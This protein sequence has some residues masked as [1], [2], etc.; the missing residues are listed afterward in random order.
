[1]PRLSPFVRGTSGSARPSERRTRSGQF[2]RVKSARRCCNSSAKNQR[3]ESERNSQPQQCAGT[4]HQ[5]SPRPPRNTHNAM[6]H[7][8]KI[9][10]GTMLLRYSR[11]RAPGTPAAI[12]RHRSRVIP[13][14][15]RHG[16]DH[17]DHDQQDVIEQVVRSGHA[18]LPGH[19]VHALPHPKVQR[20]G[21]GSHIPMNSQIYSTIQ[22]FARIRAV[23]SHRSRIFQEL[24]LV[25]QI[26]AAERGASSRHA[27]SGRLPA[28]SRAGASPAHAHSWPACPRASHH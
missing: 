18:R 4:K 19:S 28:D 20:F 16:P 7:A 17:G 1:M 22:L 26:Q 11:A 5:R 27:N 13:P 3:D 12:A 10:C 14:P 23:A 9:H 25:K 15:L 2:A 8:L 21:Q 24:A 6:M